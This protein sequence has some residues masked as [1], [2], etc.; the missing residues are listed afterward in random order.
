VSA[1]KRF[2][3]A[4]EWIPALVLAGGLAAAPSRPAGKT[5]APKP[6]A[7]PELPILGTRLSTLPEGPGRATVEKAC[8]QCHSGDMLRQQRLTEKQWTANLD[9]MIRWG[10]AVTDADKAEA[11]HYLVE[12]FG[13]DNDAFR[14][15]AVAPLSRR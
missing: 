7:A 6:P 8:L 4:L 12:H 14:P 5:A 2:V 3:N 1:R 9:K 13:P 11:L 15:V 10:A